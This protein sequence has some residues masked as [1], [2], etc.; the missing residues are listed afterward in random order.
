MTGFSDFLVY[1]EIL[2]ILVLS[3][4]FCLSVSL[5]VFVFFFISED[6][7]EFTF[8]E[9]EVRSTKEV[10]DF[11]SLSY[12]GS[13]PSLLKWIWMSGSENPAFKFRS[14]TC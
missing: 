1:S 11:C 10:I 2:S 7:D 3:I 4:L 8:F 14:C 9:K 13:F 12:H 6:T 5:C